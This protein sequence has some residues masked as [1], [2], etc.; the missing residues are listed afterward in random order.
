MRLKSVITASLLL[1]P[2]NTEMH[3]MGGERLQCGE[4]D[5]ILTSWYPVKPCTKCCQM[6]LDDSANPWIVFNIFEFLAV[7]QYLL[8]AATV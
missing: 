7:L 6:R 3:P 5:D 8:L 4:V 2:R 1:Q